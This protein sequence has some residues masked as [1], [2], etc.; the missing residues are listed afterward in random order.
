VLLVLLEVARHRIE[1]QQSV[2]DIEGQLAGE[3]S[4]SAP[5]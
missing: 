5:R 3:V 1:L 4:D 2:G